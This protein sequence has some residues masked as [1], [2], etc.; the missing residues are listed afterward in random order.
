MGKETF[1]INKNITGML[2]PHYTSILLILGRKQQSYLS[3]RLPL[4]G[5]LKKIKKLLKVELSL[6]EKQS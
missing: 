3:L 2:I 4:L 6:V 1:P 5:I